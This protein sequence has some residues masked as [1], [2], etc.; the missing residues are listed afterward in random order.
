MKDR[1]TELLER[2]RHERPMYEAWG[3]CVSEA[4]IN[5]IGEEIFPANVN[6]FI[7]IPLKHRTKEEG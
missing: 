7:R 4:L 3:A 6:L 5:A 2:W 1:E